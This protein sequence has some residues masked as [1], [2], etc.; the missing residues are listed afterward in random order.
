MIDKIN[1]KAFKSIENVSLELG[2]VNVF[3]GAN[4]SG[5]SNILEGV[6]ILSAAAHGRVDDMALLIRGV[7]PGVQALYK[8]AFPGVRINH[9]EFAAE[10]NSIS[11]IPS[12]SYK[13]SL[14]NPIVQGNYVWQYHT[15]NLKFGR[16]KIVGRSHH[17]AQ[18][19]DFSVG[20][21]ALKAAD[22]DPNIDDNAFNILRTLQNYAIYTPTTS[23]LRGIVNDSY[24]KTPLGLNGG[25]IA[26]AL[27][28][29]KKI[30][31]NNESYYE[32]WQ[33]VEDLIDWA[34]SFS[35]ASSETVPVSTAIPY[36]KNV[37]RF[38]D[39]FMKPSRNTLSGY[40]S[41]EGALF[42]LFH[43]LLLSL[44]SSP[45]FYAID[46]ADH[47]LNPRL[48]RALFEKICKWVTF[49]SCQKQILLT[50]HN[51]LVLDGL[52]LKNPQ[53]RLF[54]VS[55]SC[56]GRS[57]VTPVV[58]NEKLEELKKGKKLTLS[59]LWLSGELGGMP[60]GL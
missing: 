12:S 53:I 57:I 24:S 19:K 45:S 40:D 22:P 4:G 28:D 58:W 27:A 42:I 50:T 8:C 13:V 47:A 38:V 56:Q 31:K 34:S 37:V 5:K 35:A 49:P 54:T 41:S 51:P 43:A 20:L 44:P 2:K 10:Q 36:S 55:R 3:V 23:V 9:I 18:K 48:C 32:I 60:N 30:I 52:D 16:K 21:A 15:E 33:D 17:S 46:N 1:I 6:G 7:R 29:F 39:R 59:K 11:D 26:D 14:F 25:H